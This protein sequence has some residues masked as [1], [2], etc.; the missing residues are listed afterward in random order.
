MTQPCYNLDPDIFFPELEIEYD[1]NDKPLRP[2]K[3]AEAEYL[4]K[5]DKAKAICNKCQ[6][7]SDCLEYAL[8]TNAYGIWGATS[9]QD[10]RRIKK[11]KYRTKQK[12]TP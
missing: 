4:Q 11:A 1:K 5:V 2:T 9:E 7:V 10:R 12:S 3:E 8:K 6:F